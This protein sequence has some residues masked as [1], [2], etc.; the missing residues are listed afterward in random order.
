MLFENICP[1]I[2]TFQRIANTWISSMQRRDRRQRV[3]D[4]VR[5]VLAHDHHEHQQDERDQATQDH[6][7]R[8]EGDRELVGQQVRRSPRHSSVRS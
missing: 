5:H 6:L 8:D 2:T 1:P 3:V 4:A 7:D